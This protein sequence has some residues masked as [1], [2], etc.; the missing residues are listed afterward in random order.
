MLVGTGGGDGDDT[1][2]GQAVIFGA[3]LAAVVAPV[4]DEDLPVGLV[5][6]TFLIA[7]TLDFGVHELVAVELGGYDQDVVAG[8]ELFAP[9]DP[10]QSISQAG[11]DAGGQP[12]F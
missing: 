8:D 7:F 11:L 12:A 9:E 6:G 2:F 4:K 10:G 1:V 5:K 3:F